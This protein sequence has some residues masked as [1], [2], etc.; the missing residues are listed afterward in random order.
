M[1]V[2]T[3]L[4]RRA[5]AMSARP[6]GTIV[7]EVSDDLAPGARIMFRPEA[8]PNGEYL[9]ACRTEGLR[10]VPAQCRP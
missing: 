2:P 4:P 3:V 5:R 8:V 7:I 1:P 9:W 6:D 10:Y